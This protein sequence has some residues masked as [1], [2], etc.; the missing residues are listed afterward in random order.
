MLL[1]RI[2]GDVVVGEPQLLLLLFIAYCIYCQL[3]VMKVGRI[4]C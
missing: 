1:F 4:G 2:G 3:H